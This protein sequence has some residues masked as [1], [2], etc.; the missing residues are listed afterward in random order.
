MKEN[1]LARVRRHVRLRKKVSG[2]ADKPRIAVFKSRNHIYAQMIDDVRGV[3]LVAA[4]TLDKEIQAGGLKHGGNKEAAKRVGALLA[5]RA[6]EKGLK[7]AVF[8]RG[9]FPYH[10]RIKELA[11]SAREAGL[12]F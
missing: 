3:T 10:G 2:A 8:D 6:V 1:K 7:Q 4:S 11:D 12:E 9:G 5:K